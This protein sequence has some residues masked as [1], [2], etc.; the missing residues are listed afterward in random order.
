MWRLLLRRCHPDTGGTE[1]VFVWAMM[2]REHVAGD[3]IEEPGPRVKREPPKHKES[4]DR[5][6]YTAAFSFG[7]FTD[8]T[9]SAVNIGE[10]GSSPQ[11]R[12]LTLL[13]DCEEAPPSDIALS[14][15]QAQGA[16]Y[17]TLA[18]IAHAAGFTKP[19]RVAWY[20]LAERIPL[21]QRHA[22]HILMRLRR[23]A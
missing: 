4:G 10:Q 11:I 15:Q 17:K 8:L 9:R 7:G 23:A 6:D 22:G 20:R 14:R 19:Q 2:L 13:S 18:A 5:L 12:L 1:E 21:S 16:T 3:A